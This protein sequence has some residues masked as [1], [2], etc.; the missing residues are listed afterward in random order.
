MT[1]TATA[2]RWLPFGVNGTGTRLFCFPH[3]GASAVVYNGWR[4]YADAGLSIC[5]VQPP[6]RAERGRETLHR[7]AEALADDVVA[8]LGDEFTGN[9]ALFGHSVGALVAYLVARRLAERG[10]DLPRHLF[11]SG[12]A[13]PQLPDRRRQLRALPVAEL[14]AELRALGGL[15][16]ALLRDRSLLE[17]FLPLL[18][19]DLA[20]NETYWHRPADPLPFGLTVFGGHGDPRADHLELAAWQDLAED[21]ELV[22]YPGGH[23][24]LD[25]RAP[26]LLAVVRRRLAG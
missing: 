3:A 21:S 14:T 7:D 5:P 24:Y 1:A 18:R 23:F 13:A 20:L 12:R 22:T 19:A 15:P 11:V 2:R 10:R 25:R 6:G 8:G 16:E 17:M 9:Y 26:E 4:E